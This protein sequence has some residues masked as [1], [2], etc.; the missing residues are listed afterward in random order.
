MT[1][2]EFY[3]V[4]EQLQEENSIEEVVEFLATSLAVFCQEHDQQ[5]V[6]KFEDMN[7]MITRDRKQEMH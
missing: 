4:V 5:L 7:L 2:E 3:A 1:P 6:A